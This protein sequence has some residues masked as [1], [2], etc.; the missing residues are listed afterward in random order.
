EWL[1]IDYDKPVWNKDAAA[2]P[3]FKPAL[4]AAFQQETEAFLADWVDG[5]SSLTALLTSP[6]GF[7]GKDNAAI[8]GMTSAATTLQ[9]TSLPTT[10]RADILTQPG[11]LG[12]TAHTDG[13][14]P[15]FRGLAVMSRLLC[16]T[17]P[18]VPAMVP[19]LPPV[20]KTAIKTTRQRFQTHT[21]AAFCSGCHQFFDPMGFTFENYDGIGQWRTMENGVAVDSSGAIVGTGASDRPVA[22][23]VE[24]TQALAA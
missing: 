6:T 18:P 10:Q 19:P 9:K 16:K 11:F 5:G 7:I 21:S 12:S 15:V 17:P 13:S 3:I 20:D 1:S 14:S 4:K 2:Y 8:Y 24:L 22:N 23:A